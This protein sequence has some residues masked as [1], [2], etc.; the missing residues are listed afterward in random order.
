[1]LVVDGDATMRAL[2]EKIL[3]RDGYNVRLAEDGDQALNLLRQEPVDVVLADM[4][5]P[6]LSGLELLRILKR[7][8]PHIGIILMASRGDLHAVKDALL[9]G[10]D[11]Y[12]VRPFKSHEVSLVVER[13]YWRI[14]SEKRRQSTAGQSG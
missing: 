6:R 1:M 2:L 3:V 9:L 5:I 14:I 11:E 4:K 12:I 10:A 13:V 7:E 8:A